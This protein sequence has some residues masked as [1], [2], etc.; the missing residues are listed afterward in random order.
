[1]KTKLIV[2]IL[3][4]LALQP[5]MAEEKKQT[6]DQC[7][8]RCLPVVGEHPQEAARHADKLKA[9]RAKREGVTDPA[10]LKRLDQDE[11]EEMEKHEDKLEKICRDL[12]KYFPD[13]LN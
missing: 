3:M 5:V 12:C 4:G 8:A 13:T 6:R 11:S 7:I 1:M 2:A 10:L 9:I